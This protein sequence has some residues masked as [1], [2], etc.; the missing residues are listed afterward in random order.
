MA[1]LKEERRVNLRKK[2]E[3]SYK[4]ILNAL[5]TENKSIMRETATRNLN[6]VRRLRQR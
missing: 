5:I 2:R 1:R 6:K 3:R 4:I